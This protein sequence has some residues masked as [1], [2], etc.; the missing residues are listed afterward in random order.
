MALNNIT[1]WTNTWNIKMS[2]PKSKAML[3]CYNRSSQIPTLL[4]ENQPLEFVNTHQFLG[5][6]KD[7]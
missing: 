3:F 5:I 7:S 4:L 2:A 6:I 1:G